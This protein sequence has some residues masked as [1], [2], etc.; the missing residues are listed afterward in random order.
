MATL[1]QLSEHYKRVKRAKQRLW[2]ALRD[3]ENAGLIQCPEEYGD[4]YWKPLNELG[5]AFEEISKTPLANAVQS[6]LDSEVYGF[7]VRK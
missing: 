3:A 7:R 4:G 1:K 6:E 5:S 2:T